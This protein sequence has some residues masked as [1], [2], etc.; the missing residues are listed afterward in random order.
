METIRYANGS[1]NSQY[2]NSSVL[3]MAVPNSLSFLLETQAV[4]SVTP[5][6]QKK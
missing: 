2:C 5:A 4:G 6:L 1:N 3:L